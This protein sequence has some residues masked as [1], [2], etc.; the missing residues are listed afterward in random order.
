MENLITGQNFPQEDGFLVVGHVGHQSEA[1]RC[2]TLKTKN[3][4]KVNVEKVS[5]PDRQK[6][7]Q[8]L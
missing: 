7:V 3:Q 5:K 6:S 1:L 4:I 2:V 8:I